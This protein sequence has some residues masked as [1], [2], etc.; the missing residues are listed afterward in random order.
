MV[1]AM[2]KAVVVSVALVDTVDVAVDID[3]DTDAA[4]DMAVA[5][6]RP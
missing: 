4:V 5:M 1:V 2:D 6:A 3:V